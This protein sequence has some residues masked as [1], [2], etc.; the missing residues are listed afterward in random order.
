VELLRSGELVAGNELESKTVSVQ[1]DGA[2]TR[3]RSALKE[4]CPIENFGKSQSE[5][6][7]KPGLG[8][9]KEA[10]RH[11]MFE[12]LWRE[13]KVITIYMHDSEGR[14]DKKILLTIDGT[15]GDAESIQ[16][17]VALHLHRLGAANAK[18][19][20]KLAKIPSTVAIYR[21]LDVYHAC[22]NLNKALSI[23]YPDVIERREIYRAT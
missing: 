1:I 21:I 13:P 3:I 4:L 10:R 17:I 6:T 7:G 8:R 2:R 11:A 9:S 15:F 23:L 5:A 18:S 22:E 19:I 20:L 16:M 14:R 12:A